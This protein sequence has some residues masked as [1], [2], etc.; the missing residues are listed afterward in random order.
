MM[1]EEGQI[2][3]IRRKWKNTMNSFGSKFKNINRQFSREMLPMLTQE[4]MKS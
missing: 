2:N 4:K 1:G 3:N